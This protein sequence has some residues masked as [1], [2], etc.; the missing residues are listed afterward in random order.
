MMGDDG[1]SDGDKGEVDGRPYMMTYI[2]DDPSPFAP[3][4]EWLDVRG[5]H[6]A[7]SPASPRYRTTV[8]RIYAGIG[9]RQTPPE[10]LAV[11]ERIAEA[12]ARDGWTL[13]SGG[14]AGADAAFERGCYRAGGDKQIFLPHPGYNDHP[15]PLHSVTADML[16]LAAKHH[17]KWETLPEPARLLIARNGA[18]VLGPDLASPVDVVVCWTQGGSAKGGTGQAIRVATDRGIPIVN[19]GDHRAA[20]LEATELVARIAKAGL[21]ET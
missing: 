1:G 20:G 2:I 7:T 19:L 13:R 18:Q 10:I 9:S 14:A 15:S 12:L 11:M 5:V 16:A 8:D 6:P 17:P 21:G 4:E 3:L